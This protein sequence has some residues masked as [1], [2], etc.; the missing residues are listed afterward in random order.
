MRKLGIIL[1]SI[2]EKSSSKSLAKAMLP[3]FPESVEVSFIR[4][5]D[6]PLF[7]PDIDK[8]GR[9]PDSYERFRQAIREQDALLFITPEYNRTI[10][11]ALKNAI[12]IGS[13][14]YQQVAFS[15]KPAMIISQS[16]GSLAG[17]GANHH[18]R[19]SLV[20]L[21]VPVMPQPEI[22]L[23]HIH[24][25]VDVQGNFIDSTAAQFLTDSVQAFLDFAK[26][27]ES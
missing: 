22:Y 26:R 10:P 5:E 12:E 19:Q 11:A 27:F 13:R 21:N 14:P 23:A 4:I 25:I 17:F 18:L 2:K 8:E 7:N 15:G 1:G 24:T 3:L 6:L 20:F 9:R 16:N